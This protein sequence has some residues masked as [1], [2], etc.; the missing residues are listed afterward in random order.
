MKKTGSPSGAAALYLVKSNGQQIGSLGS[1]N[2]QDL[3]TSYSDRTFS[4]TQTTDSSDCCLIF[5]REDGSDVGSDVYFQ[6]ART[7]SGTPPSDTTCP[8]AQ[9]AEDDSTPTIDTAAFLKTAF[10]YGG[11]PS[12]SASLLPPPVAWI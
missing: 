4:G 11:T 6:Y 5:A 2:L 1:I 7:D 9:M 12:S 8:L 3:P 10:T